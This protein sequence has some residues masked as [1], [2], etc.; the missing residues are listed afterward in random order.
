[1]LNRL[2]YPLLICFIN[3]FGVKKNVLMKNIFARETRKR[4]CNLET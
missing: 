4:Q 1:M 3:F 2:L